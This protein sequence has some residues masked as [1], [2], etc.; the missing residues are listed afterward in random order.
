[1]TKFLSIVLSVVTL[2]ACGKGE[3]NEELCEQQCDLTQDWTDRCAD[4]LAEGD[5]EVEGTGESCVAEC[6]ED[7]DEAAAAG[8]GTQWTAVAKCVTGITTED[9]ECDPFAFVGA[10]LEECL[11][12][13]TAFEACS[14]A[15]GDDDTGL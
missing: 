13:L 1:M 11:T 7:A 4:E 2:A 14:P 12:Q 3:T 5:W 10:L 9:L 15:G 8:C 6:V